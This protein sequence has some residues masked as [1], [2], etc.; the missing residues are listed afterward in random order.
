MWEQ[1]T[2]LLVLAKNSFTNW[3]RCA[4][5]SLAEDTCSNSARTEAVYDECISSNN[6]FNKYIASAFG[7]DLFDHFQSP[8]QHFPLSLKSEAF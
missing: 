4:A 2:L 1:S 8:M 3:D 5:H 6:I 7:D